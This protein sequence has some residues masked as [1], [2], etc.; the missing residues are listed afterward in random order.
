M[1][2]FRDL[3]RSGEEMHRLIVG[4]ENVT[5]DE[6]N[7]PDVLEIRKRLIDYFKELDESGDL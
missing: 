4:G 1:K 5:E 6:N 7:H 3:Q 2:N